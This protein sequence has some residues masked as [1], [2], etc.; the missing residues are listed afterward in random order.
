METADWVINQFSDI[1]EGG[2][3]EEELL[4]LQYV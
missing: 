3:L 1:G 4:E 2:V